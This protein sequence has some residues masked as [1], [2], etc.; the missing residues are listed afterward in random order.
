MKSIINTQD[1]ELVVL[2]RDDSGRVGLYVRIGED[3]MGYN[4][5]RSV[6]VRLDQ[7]QTQELIDTL[8]K[9]FHG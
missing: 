6:T 3:G 7:Q 9:A 1:Q 8:Q 2:R 5:S 4:T